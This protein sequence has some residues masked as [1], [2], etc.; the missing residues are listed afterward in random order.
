MSKK[1]LIVVAI[2]VLIAGLGYA[3]Y[4]AW[5]S[6]QALARAPAGETS[7]VERGSL[8]V[9]ASG[10]GSLAPI[11]DVSLAFPLS[12]RVAEV[13]VEEGEQVQA[14]QPLVR[15]DSEELE[16]QVAQAEASLAVAQAQLAQLLA[17][18]RPEEIAAQEANLEAARA[19]VSAAAA[20][21]DRVTA[22]SSAAQI[23]SVEAQVASATA[24]QKRALDL[25][26]RTME[27]RTIELP[28][29]AILPDGTVLE[30]SVEKTI[31]P[32]LG[33]PEE[34]AR[35]SLQVAEATLAAAQ[36]R[37]D[38]LKAG[39]T[40]EE[41][42]EAQA[43][44]AAAVAQRDAAQAR[45]DKLLTEPTEEQ[46]Q[47]QQAAVD[48]A[49]AALDEA[50]QRLEKA[51]LTAPISGTVTLLDV[52][53]G[54]LAGANQ[55][56]VV[57][58][59]LTTLQVDVYL[60]ETDAARVSV[61]QEA[62]V[63]LEAFPEVGLS[64]E[65]TYVAPTAQIESGVAL[66]RV[67]VRLEPTE[68]TPGLPARAG[69]TADVDIVVASRENALIIPLR[70]VHSEGERTYVERLVAGEDGQ[71]SQNNRVEQVDVTLGLMTDTQVEITAG[72]AEG[73]VVI[74]VP[75]PVQTQRQ[76]PMGFF[77]SGN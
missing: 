27:C 34:Q 60:S 57:L 21:R 40:A 39:A 37:L 73:D 19:R 33:A 43:N 46:I 56:V 5:Q 72:L 8:L 11:A 66:Y 52:E 9:A 36:A 32:M 47:T 30:K 54:M 75:G 48:E 59:D 64:G 49:R 12:G 1:H 67:T 53:P 58:S 14:G 10:S 25:H 44:V 24:Q 15:L 22:G 41:I 77:G 4:D 29:G 16:L 42:R 70:A 28:A 62:R 23:A 51:T 45:L 7:V 13:L 71:G 3:G 74:V 26:E 63:T 55:P 50:R 68:L 38:E 61:G 69:M 17:P 20:N 76:G 2:V 6:R 65:V 35:Y 31:C 18:P